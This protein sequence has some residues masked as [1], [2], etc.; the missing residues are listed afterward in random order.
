[1][2]GLS[3]KDILEEEQGEEEEGEKEEN[4]VEQDNEGE[5]ED[6]EEEDEDDEEDEQKKKKGGICMAFIR[7][8]ASVGGLFIVLA[9]YIVGGAYAFIYFESKLEEEERLVGIAR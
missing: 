5:E 3:N 1:M 4:E 2:Q 8:L 6:Y 7:F 9:G